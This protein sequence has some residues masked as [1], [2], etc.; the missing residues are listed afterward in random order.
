MY[1][2]SERIVFLAF[3]SSILL[4]LPLIGCESSPKK[5]PTALEAVEQKLSAMKVKK[6]APKP[7]PTLDSSPAELE[8][9]G[10][11]V[12]DQKAKS[13][14]PP[15]LGQAYPDLK[16]TDQNG[17]TVQLSSFKGKVILLEPVAMTCAACNAFSGGNQVGPFPGAQAQN[18][19]LSIEEYVAKYSGGASLRKQRIIFVQLVIYNM[20]NEAPSKADIKSWANHFKL[21]GVKNFYVLAGSKDLLTPASWNMIPGFQL[22]DKNFTLVSDSTGHN[23]KHNLFKTLLPMIKKVM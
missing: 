16:L 14:W 3:L 7:K 1:R 10:E 15:V 13:F 20:R 4:L 8:K 6:K 18:G 17:K 9:F 22:I 11:S 2:L 21:S 5:E 12:V 19:L 23:P